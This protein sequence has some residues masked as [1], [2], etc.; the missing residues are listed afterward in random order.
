MSAGPLSKPMWNGTLVAA[1]AC[2]A[3]CDIAFGLTFQ[4]QPLI[5]EAQGVPAWQIG[6]VVAMGP[7]GILLAGP[8]LPRLMHR[9]GGKAMCAAAI[10]TLVVMLFLFKLLPPLWWWMALRFIFGIA[11]GA[12][13]TVSETWVLTMSSPETRGRI[14]GLYTSILSVTFGIGPTIIP[15]TGIEGWAPWL[16]CIGFVAA[17]LIPLAFVEGSGAQETGEESGSLIGVISRQPFIFANAVAATL[18]D[19][20]L[21]SFFTIFAVRAGLPLAAASSLLG[22]AIIGGVFL[23]YPMGMLADKWSRDG[24]I[25]GCV[26]LTIALGLLIA[27]LLSTWLI[28]PVMILF[29]ATGFGVYVIA[30]AAIGAAFKGKDI[31]AGSAVIASTWGVGGL[32]GPPVAGRIID[33]FGAQSVPYI[34]VGI[35]VLLFGLLASNGMRILRPEAA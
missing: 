23:Y 12:L 3:A 29:C 25:L 13:F 27:P 22:I 31:V 26:V 33:L 5:M 9:F 34:L 4:L 1:M 2:I 10:V 8:L 24:V 35:Y 19:A 18:F 14:M 16:I 6:T 7:L 11:T 20:I 32:I 17:G 30:L 21:I 15:F 28:W